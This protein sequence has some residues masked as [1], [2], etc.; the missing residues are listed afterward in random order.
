MLIMSCGADS[1]DPIIG[2]T[3]DTLKIDS[4]ILVWSDEFNDYSGAPDPMK[5]NFI[6][7]ALGWH[8]DSQYYT[9]GQN[10]YVSDNTLKIVAKK[11]EYG[12]KNYTSALMTTRDLGDWT[13]GRIEVRAKLPSSLGIFPAIWLKPTNE[14]YGSDN[15]K[16]GEIDI[17]EFVGH[18]PN[19]IYSTIH[20]FN[21]NHWD[22]T[23][24]FNEQKVENCSSEF[25]V[26]AVEWHEDS[27]FFYV[28]SLRHH[29]YGK[30]ANATTDSWPFDMDFYLLLNVA[31][32]G[33]WASDSG[34][35]ENAFPQT[36]EVDYVRVYAFPENMKD[37]SFTVVGSSNDNGSISIS[38]QK[39]IYTYNDT[40][41]VTATPD[42]GFVFYNW[43][44]DV[45]GKQNPLILPVKQDLSIEANF[46]IEG[47]LLTNTDFSYGDRS[48][49]FYT[50]GTASAQMSFDKNNGTVSIDNPGSDLWE[51]G[52]YQRDF[53]VEKGQRYRLTVEAKSD[54]NKSIEIGLQHHGEPWTYHLLKNIVLTNEMTKY[55][56]EGTL[57]KDE[58]DPRVMLNMGKSPG[59]IEIR[60][61]HLQKLK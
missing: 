3:E 53:V 46:Q 61:I 38:P 21:N 60:S 35:D 13:Y 9:N 4:L 23:Q 57:V 36:M 42:S 8:N 59:N 24:L 40:I 43:T 22:S 39:E 25:H 20:T 6:S 33:G 26:Y 44:G 58:E 5:W 45:S 18:T 15:F 2:G 48:W 41:T 49:I 27:I 37:T 55:S 51:V 54:S 31:V 12:G 29:S 30:E 28:D 47:E 11:E 56:V 17:M 14:K 19:T 50:S 1:A 7:G 52:L 32:G 10:A 16:S 34:F